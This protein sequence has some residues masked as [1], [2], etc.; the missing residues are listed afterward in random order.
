MK[1]LSKVLAFAFN[2][3]KYESPNKNKSIHDLRY[4]IQK[5]GKEPT[6]DD[7]L[8]NVDHLE[9]F[10]KVD[11]STHSVLVSSSAVASIQCIVTSSRWLE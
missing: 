1:V 10:D 8:F 11:H 6:L 9:A 2:L 4:I 7:I 5:V 3:L